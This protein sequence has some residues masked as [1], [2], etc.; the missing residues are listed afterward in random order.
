MSLRW[1]WGGVLAKA[2]SPVGTAQGQ[3]PQT[4]VLWPHP[5]LPGPSPLPSPQNALEEPPS[6]TPPQGANIPGK[7][8]PRW[9]PT[10]KAWAHLSLHNRQDQ[11]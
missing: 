10:A 6:L 4:E 5:R 3:G 9:V 2:Q 1:L 7:V 11:G 8:G